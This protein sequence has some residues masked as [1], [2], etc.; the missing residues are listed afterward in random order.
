MGAAWVT[1]MTMPDQSHINQVRDA[2]WRWPIGGASVMVGSGFSKNA[3]KIAFNADDLPSWWE[4][5]RL[6]CKELYPADD[7]RLQR[8]LAEASATSGFLRLAQEYK[9]A[10]GRNALHQ[11]IKDSIRDDE[12]KPGE[13][14]RRLLRL[15]WR[16]VFTTN[17]DTLLEQSRSQVSERSYSIV[18]SVADLPTAAPPRIFKLHGSL[19]SHYPLIFTEEDYRTY[20]QKFAPLVNT[21]QQ[22]MMETMFLL[23]GFS[24]DDPNF[25]HWSGWVRD[26]LGESAPK[27][28]LAGWL[29][30]S[31]HR[32]H[33]LM[34]RK[35]I[36]IDLARHPKA[37]EWPEHLRERYAAEWILLTLESGRPYD[38]T[39]WPTPRDRSP[40]TIHH[41]LDPV[42]A[43]VVDQPRREPTAPSS[44]AALASTE[45]IRELLDVWKHNRNTYPGWIIVPGGKREGMSLNTDAWERHILNACSEFDAIERLEALHEL[46]WRREMLLD[47]ISSETERIATGAIWAIDC[48]ART[49][50]GVEHSGGNW[51]AVRAAWRAVALALATRARQRFDRERFDRIIEALS[52]YLNDEE[53]VLQGVLHERCLWALY[54][55]DFANVG[56]LLDRWQTKNCDPI[57]MLRK[58]AILAETHRR[59]D[60]R[61]LVD[62]ARD[63]IRAASLNRR[64]FVGPSR[65]GWALFMAAALEQDPSKWPDSEALKR[66]N[67]RWRELAI[68]RCDALEEKRLYADA[69]R[70]HAKE[71]EPDFDLGY[72][73]DRVSFSGSMGRESAALRTIR[74]TE[75]A[76]L[77]PSVTPMAISSDILK[78]AAEAIV[79]SEPLLASQLV[80]RICTYDGDGVLKRIFSRVRVA[81]LPVDAVSAL[82][83]S[84]IDCIEYSLGRMGRQHRGSWVERLRVAIEVLS[85]IVLRLQPAQV[86]ATLERALT[87]Y[88]NRDMAG[89]P[90][91]TR[92]I[93]NLL[94]RCWEALPEDRRT[95]RVLDLLNAPIVGLDGFDTAGGGHPHLDPAEIFLDRRLVLPAR[96][97]GNDERWRQAASLLIRGLRAG[98]APR[99][100]AS[101][102]IVLPGMRD[103]LIDAELAQV[104]AALWHSDYAGP[105]DLPRETNL[106]DWTFLQLPEP[107]TGLAEQRFRRKWLSGSILQPPVPRRTQQAYSIPYV[108]EP[109]D[110]NGVIFQIGLALTELKRIGRTLNIS[111]EETQMLG[112]FVDEWCNMEM[113]PNIDGSSKWAPTQYA[114]V[115]LGTI[116]SEAIVTD[117]TATKIYEKI[118]E[119]HE[120]KIPTYQLIGGLAKILPNRRDD[121]VMIMRMG[122]VTDHVDFAAHA[123]V[124]LFEW[125]R[126]S[127]GSSSQLQP[128][129]D[130]LVREIGI[131]IATRRKGML[132]QA[133]Q[134]AD[135]IFADG[136]PSQKETIQELAIQGLGYLME[137]L[138]Y[139]RQGDRNIEEFDVPGL[140]WRCAQ[141]AVTLSRTGLEAPVVARWLE[142]IGDDPLPE[143]R[144]TNPVN[145]APRTIDQAQDNPD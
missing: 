134:I 121:L 119:L 1:T 104:A 11:F 100:R 35:V 80:L 140:R 109:N 25:L 48:G 40:D 53:G 9:A 125:L 94:N 115:G 5:T 116:L 47:R 87:Y 44:R 64:S 51:T 93:R 58:A 57:W 55:A 97:P 71:G 20:P 28:Y 2:L 50:D 83:H 95:D 39:E 70:I 137:E 108:P 131:T 138:R 12:F 84:C 135:L 21:A 85:R 102:R 4:L 74:L 23:I 127:T 81:A 24:G 139:D 59:D 89:H 34:E 67:R 15:P 60:A 79:Y 111:I 49:V 123:A 41:L 110:L 46:I 124:G 78:V 77:P 43:P 113:P 144:Y 132:D 65:E 129:P 126:A 27:I 142:A 91:L 98:G 32:R 17:W 73:T 143:V 33:L 8:A 117:S 3:D 56:A 141:L 68:S 31:P 42:E 36:P 136:S 16:D 52:P 7:A 112:Q 45:A 6:I 13:M 92:P 72:R 75:V 86:D 101:I 88:S 82:M 26:E 122:L 76:A 22:A 63:E 38:I 106:Y 103:R 61:G 18:H 14:H 30:L 54:S 114:V 128:P 107:R 145:Y 96:T 130:D 19:P 69:M 37:G 29:D 105:D 90:W 120:S 118:G 10:F 66:H 99:K 133:L 62:H